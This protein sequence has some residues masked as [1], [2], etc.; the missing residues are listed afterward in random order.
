MQNRKNKVAE[1]QAKLGSGKQIL[2]PSD[3][4]S[5][6]DLIT[7]LHS[8]KE[9]QAVYTKNIDAVQTRLS[10]EETV[11]TSMTQ[12]MQRV[13]QLTIQA[14]NDTLSGP[15]RTV[16]AAEV[17]SLRDELLNLA[18][19]RDISGNYIFS[20]NKFSSPA[21]I[22]SSSGTV[23]YNG[24]YGRFKVNVSDVEDDSKYS[25]SRA[26]FHCRLCNPR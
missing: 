20:G 9:R 17:K 15:D 7:R 12:I 24:D 2:S 4:P 23:S 19:T 6:S 18:N 11:L 10:S 16:I 1:T 25:R 14:S 5:K 26:I 21:F 22:E 8:A 3:N 13:K